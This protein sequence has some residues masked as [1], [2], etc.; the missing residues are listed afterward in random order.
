MKSMEQEKMVEMEGRVREL[1]LQLSL[2]SEFT[3]V[4]PCT[5]LVLGSGV[6][7]LLL[8]LLLLLF[9]CCCCYRKG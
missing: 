6:V 1:C 3:E 8:L 2:P 4:V 7:L 5:Y 9:C